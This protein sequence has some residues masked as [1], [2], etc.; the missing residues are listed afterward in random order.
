MTSAVIRSRPSLVAFAAF[1]IFALAVGFGTHL[2]IE[3]RAYLANGRDLNDRLA[4]ALDEHT[5]AVFDGIDHALVTTAE[6]LADARPGGPPNEAVLSRALEMYHVRSM[7]VIDPAGRRLYSTIPTAQPGGDLSDRDYFVVQRDNP[8]VALFI[9]VPI[10]GR[11]SGEWVIPASRRL[12]AADGG[13][14]GVIQATLAQDTFQDFFRSLQIGEN[15]VVGIAR[16]DGPILIREPAGGAIGAS[17]AKAPLLTRYL[18]RSPVGTYRT[19]TVIDGVDRIV[20][21]RALPSLG[22]VVYVSRAVD[23][24]LAAWKRDLRILSTIFLACAAVIT[25]FA[26]YLF[27]QAA[28]REAAEAAVKDSERRFRTLIEQSNDMITVVSPDG[29]V[30][31][32]SP[33]SNEV[34]G[35]APAEVMG[36][37]LLDR[38][39]PDDKACVA[40][41]L[42]LVAAEPGRRAGGCTRVRHRDGTWRD[43]EWTARNAIGVAGLEGIVIN[44]R[45]ITVRKQIEADLQRAKTAAEAAS[46]AKSAFL[47]NMSHE[48]RTPLNAV[49]GFSEVIRNQVLGPVGIE[50]YREYATDINGAGRHLLEIIN[51]I[52]DLSKLDAMKLQLHEEW[53]VVADL[54]ASTVTILRGEAE[55]KD[56]R[57]SIDV[58][59]SLPALWVDPLR[60]RQVL[61]NL[62]SNAV[63]FTPAGGQVSLSAAVEASGEL[64]LVIRDTGIGMT[65]AQIET[66]LQPFGQANVSLN[67]PQ[68]GT[69]LGLPLA[70]R[71][72]ELHGGR[73]D[74]VSTPDAGTEMTVRMPASRLLRTEIGAAM[75]TTEELA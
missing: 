7:A 35:H 39:H 37:P 5:Q 4:L 49:I 14:A 34:L 22:L 11:A 18:P 46:R 13:F 6:R 17:L 2:L 16:V 54:V 27:G 21:Y 29:I 68:Q 41:A 50:R 47:A 36:S 45:D 33:S 66:A 44:S 71:L 26:A 32:R 72:I 31:Y 73:L 56:L 1:A 30:T 48:L 40:D 25:A 65:E 15:A 60:I 74:I 9:G 69:G 63:K 10:F 20:S 52:L 53:C 70:K 8:P 58:P 75:A 23:D 19:S 59:A 28:R 61:T 67:R 12:A 24:V 38:V 64:A 3:Y 42:R 55:T 62:L 51:D 43:I 57:L